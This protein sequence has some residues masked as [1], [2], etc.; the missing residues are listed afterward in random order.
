MTAPLTACPNRLCGHLGLFHDIYELGDPY[1]TC[2]IA[3]CGCGHP[4]DVVLRKTDDGTVSVPWGAGPVIAVASQLLAD[5]DPK[6]WDGDTLTLDTAGRYRYQML[7]RDPRDE[8]LLIF[9]RVK[10]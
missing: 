7:R 3:G 8:R 9:G 4:S 6:H 2:V 5:I 1:P 10:P